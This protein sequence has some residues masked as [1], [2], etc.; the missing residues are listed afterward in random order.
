MVDFLSTKNDAHLYATGFSPLSTEVERRLMHQLGSTNLKSS[1][2]C[3]ARSMLPVPSWLLA[4]DHQG[5]SSN[6]SRIQT[7]SHF[8][9]I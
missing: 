7:P 6:C 8:P 4:L 3:Q 2:Q 1:S 5:K 9:S